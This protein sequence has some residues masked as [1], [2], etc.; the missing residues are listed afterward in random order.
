MAT[1]VNEA[2]KIYDGSCPACKDARGEIVIT[3]DAHSCGICWACREGTMVTLLAHT[4][5][6]KLGK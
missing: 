6:V 1:K 2:G 3:V 4:C 5:E